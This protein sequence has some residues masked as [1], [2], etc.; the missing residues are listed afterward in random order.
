ME[1]AVDGGVASIQRRTGMWAGPTAVLPK[2]MWM[3]KHQDGVLHKVCAHACRV[4]G[5]HV[6]SDLGYYMHKCMR[7]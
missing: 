4:L 2:L 7:A 1:A 6:Y 5:Q 3:M